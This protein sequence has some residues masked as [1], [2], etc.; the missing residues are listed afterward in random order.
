MLCVN[1]E[2]LALLR[3]L[4][5]NQ[6]ESK[7]YL[8][9]VNSSASTATELSDIANIPRPRV[10]DVLAKL[11]KKGFVVTKPGRPAK[12]SA[13]PLSAAV[14]AL[15]KERE[16]SYKKEVGELERLEEQLLSQIATSTIES[17][18]EEDV[19]LVSDR[20][21]IYATLADLIDKAQ[22]HVCIYSHR[23][24]LAR[25]RNEYGPRLHKAQKRGV[26]VKLVESQKRLAVVDDHALI[27]LNNASDPRNDKAAWIRSRF[28]AQNL[29]E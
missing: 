11:E 19:F 12:Y 17:S 26:K 2:T 27:F 8:A 10:Y 14:H 15:K 4:G 16:E 21:N 23:E 9:L 24:G 29:K 18:S 13:V 25:K 1:K 3:R 28:A 5:L 6:Y 20:K 22:E 7:T